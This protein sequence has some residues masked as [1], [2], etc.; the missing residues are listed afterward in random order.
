MNRFGLQGIFG[1]DCIVRDD[2]PYVIEVNPRYTASIEVLEQGNSIPALAV[3]PGDAMVP[4]S[5]EVFGKAILFAQRGVT[6]PERFDISDIADIPHA[7]EIIAKGRPILTIFARGDSV[8]ACEN[9]L[10]VRT[11]QVEQML[12][13]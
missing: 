12:F 11:A 10:R 4:K 13:R 3:R 2:I 6:F 8:N 1:V 5:K 9:E 7:G